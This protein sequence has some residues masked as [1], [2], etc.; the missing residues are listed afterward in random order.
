MHSI[1]FPPFSR[2]GHG[3][4]VCLQCSRRAVSLVHSSLGGGTL[5][6]GMHSH[7]LIVLEV[8]DT[9]FNPLVKNAN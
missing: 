7:R 8:R 6:E 2:F 9:V 4:V 5:E 1:F 3:F